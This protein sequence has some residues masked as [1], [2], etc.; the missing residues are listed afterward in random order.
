MTHKM[1]DILND[2]NLCIK[3]EKSLLIHGHMLVIYQ[4]VFS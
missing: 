4:Y 3:Y 2:L 1:E